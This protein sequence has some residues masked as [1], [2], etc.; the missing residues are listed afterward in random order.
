MVI[1]I[2]EFRLSPHDGDSRLACFCWTAYECR[3][4]P[5]FSLACVLT[6]LLLDASLQVT[7][8]PLPRL[9]FTD[10]HISHLRYSEAP[11]FPLLPTLPASLIVITARISR[12]C[13][14][15]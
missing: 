7:R 10:I 12:P 6:S 8:S 9:L 1:R 3:C 14:S 5:A 4:L 2:S 11:G 15:Q 13:C